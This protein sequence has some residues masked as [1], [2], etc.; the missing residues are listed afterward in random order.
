MDDDQDLL[1]YKQSFL[2]ISLHIIEELPNF[3]G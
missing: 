3:I 1:R 2:K